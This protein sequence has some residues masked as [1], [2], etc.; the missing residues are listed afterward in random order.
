MDQKIHFAVRAMK[1]GVSMKALCCE[2]GIGWLTEDFWLKQFRD[3]SGVR[4]LQEH[5]RRLHDSP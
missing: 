5:S 2:F 4:G 1:V 3:A